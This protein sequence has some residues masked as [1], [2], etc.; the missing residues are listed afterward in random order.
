MSSSASPAP[1]PP[2]RQRQ[3]WIALSGLAILALALWAL[4][5]EFSAQGYDQLQ[6]ALRALPVHDV[7]LSL[8]LAVCSYACLIGFDALGI[9]RSGHR[10]GLARLLPT[11]LLAH[12]LSHTTG[13][14][15]IT[16]GAV[17]ARGYASAGM[18]LGDIAGV[19]ALVSGGFA[20]GVW[21][22]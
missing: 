12:A 17:R 9:R 7:V 15:P 1:H 3:R 16:G 11:A 13:F 18:G 8:L 5:R 22:L 19:V 4:H 10:V 2:T 6:A 21:G 20:L 14:G